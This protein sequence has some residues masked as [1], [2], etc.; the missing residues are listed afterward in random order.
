MGAKQLWKIIPALPVFLAAPPLFAIHILHRKR[1]ATTAVLVVETKQAGCAVDIDGAPAGTTNARGLLTISSVEP[2]DHYVHVDCPGKR[3]KTLLVTLQAGQKLELPATGTRGSPSQFEIA[4]NQTTIHQLLNKAIELRSDGHFPEAI[5]T[6]RKAVKL[7]PE[8]P[9]LHHELAT[10][11]L[12][13]GQWYNAR[14]ELLETL[15]Y[16]ANDA[17]AHNALGFAYEKLGDLNDAVKQYRIAA[18]LDPNDDS[19]HR[20]YLEALALLPPQRLSKKKK[21]K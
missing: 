9:N 2:D 21:R 19:Y 13:F 10:T 5:Q 15:R 1:P 20:H 7:D 12:M 4:E 11:F 14:V 8:N 17:D 3:E 6:L 16:D 18:R